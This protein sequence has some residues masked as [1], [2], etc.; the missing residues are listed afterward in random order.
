MKRE[1]KLK[2]FINNLNVF[3]YH[4]FVSRYLLIIVILHTKP[5]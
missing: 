3:T 1:K 2:L 4:G 5:M